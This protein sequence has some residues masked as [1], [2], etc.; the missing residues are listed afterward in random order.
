RSSRRKKPKHLRDLRDLRGQ[1]SCT[2]WLVSLWLQSRMRVLS[3]LA[4]VAVVTL[5]VPS[6]AQR[7]TASSYLLYVASEASDRIALVRFDG[8]SL[9]VERD[10]GTGVMPVDIDGP[11]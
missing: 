6:R 2:S 11:H 7:S 10:F 1:S 8:A 4:V 9:H 5:G 3:F